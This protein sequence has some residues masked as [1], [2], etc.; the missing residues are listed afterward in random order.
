MKLSRK[1]RR[2]ALQEHLSQDPFLT[3]SQLAQKLDVSVAT[4]R[5][6]RMALDIPELRKRAKDIASSAHFQLRA[7]Q[8]EGIIGELVELDLGR[9]AASVLLATDQMA[10]QSTEILRGYFLF[11][12]GNS[13]AVAVIDSKLPL[14][15]SSH[16]RFYKSVK[17]GQQV[18]ATAKIL[19]VQ[20]NRY[21]IKVESFVQDEIVFSGEY[22]IVDAA[23]EGGWV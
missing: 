16:V 8:G 14:I 13:L 1:E 5:L 11:A 20:A 4:I 9:Q 6:D 7:L 12:Q 2:Q 17:S 3:D 22:I 10:L 18:L 23:N 21:T 19:S 15:K